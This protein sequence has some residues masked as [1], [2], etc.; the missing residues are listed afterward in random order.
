MKQRIDSINENEAAWIKMQLES[1]AKFVE[2]FSQ[3]DAEKPLTLAA[4]DRA[5]AA[6]L[7]SEPTEIDLI[8]AVINY[9]G[10]A[11]GQAL[12]DGI[13]LKWVIASD[14]QGS[15]L[16]VH[17]FPGRAFCSIPQISLPK[18]GN[19]VRL[20]FLKTHTSKSGVM[21]AHYSDNGTPP[22][23]VDWSARD[24]RPCLLQ[25]H[26]WRSRCKFLNGI[27]HRY[28]GAVK[29][30]VKKFYAKSLAITPQH[31][32]CKTFYNPSCSVSCWFFKRLFGAVCREQP[33]TTV[34]HCDD[35]PF[36]I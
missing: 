23:Q 3:E 33:R 13:G 21:F 27:D 14:D 29:G 35:A 7:A 24:M 28:V 30:F 34:I 17:G 25:R 22:S 5:F 31:F 15:E 32:V 16:A 6:W 12:V 11:F 4:L 19:D 20:I 8:N 9:V 10:I 1:A 18:G 2:G 26:H 36:L